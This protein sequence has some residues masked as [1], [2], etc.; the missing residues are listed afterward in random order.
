[1][2]KYRQKIQDFVAIIPFIMVAVTFLC[3]VFSSWGFY[4]KL[5]VYLPDLLGYS[6]LTNIVFLYH[7]SFRKYCNPTKICVAGLLIMNVVSMLTKG[8][9]Y[10]NIMN[11]IWITGIIVFILIVFKVKRW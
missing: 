6:I 8:T 5:F 1:M 2:I 7:Y 11:D 3:A 10:Y 4:S 9:Q